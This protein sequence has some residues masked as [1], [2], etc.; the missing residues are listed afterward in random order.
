MLSVRSRS[1]DCTAVGSRYLEHALSLHIYLYDLRR[2]FLK[3]LE[4]SS[5]FAISNFLPGPLRVRDSGSRLYFSAC[6]DIGGVSIEADNGLAFSSSSWLCHYIIYCT[7][8]VGNN[9]K[10]KLLYIRHIVD[11]SL[12]TSHD[13]FGFI[14]PLQKVI[15]L[16]PR[17]T[18]F[19]SVL[20]IS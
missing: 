7:V 3:K 2:Q 19:N 15:G 1:A 11:I 16:S 13:I 20:I 8:G 6:C 4:I 5:K 18:T 9:D 10:S 17:S 12:L 14:G